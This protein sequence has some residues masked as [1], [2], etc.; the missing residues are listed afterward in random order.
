MAVF[1][2]LQLAQ[3]Q[4]GRLGYYGSQ[5][6]HLRELDA[7]AADRARAPA[8]LAAVARSDREGEIEEWLDDH[9]VHSGG[10][11]AQSLTSLGF[12]REDL[13]GLGATFD[14]AGMPVVAESCSM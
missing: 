14:P 7:L 1:E 13:D 2:R 10:E 3:L 6:E 8:Q 11:I 4:L 12:S 9:G 5:L